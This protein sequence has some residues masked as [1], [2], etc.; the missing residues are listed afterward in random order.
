MK[1]FIPILLI[2]LLSFPAC[3]QNSPQKE[4]ESVMVTNLLVAAAGVVRLCLKAQSL[5][6]NYRGLIL[7]LTLMNPAPK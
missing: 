3:S 5:L 4:K 1:S 7:K 2:L 6:K